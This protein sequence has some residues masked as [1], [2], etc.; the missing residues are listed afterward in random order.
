MRFPEEVLHKLADIIRGRPI[1]G[2]DQA[3]T[4]TFS[5]AWIGSYFSQFGGDG[6]YPPENSPDV[7]QYV[8]KFLVKVNGTPSMD[9]LL[10]A[11]P[12]FCANEEREQFDPNA[13][14]YEI[15]K[16]I[17]AH[18]VSL[19]KEDETFSGFSGCGFSVGITRQEQIETVS[20]IELNDQTIMEH[21]EKASSKIENE[22]YAGAISSSYTLIEGFL[23]ELLRRLDITFNPDEG[24]IRKL[25][26]FAADHLNLN[27]KGEHLESYLKAILQGIKSQVSGLYEL[28]NKAS[29]R[30]ARRYHPARHH[31]KLAVNASFTLCEFLLDSFVYQQQRSERKVS[32]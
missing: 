30:H 25:Y 16:V 8:F 4:P 15:N 29:D 5:V 14:A 19:V 11:L 9:G 20:L 32:A 18:G 1:S 28:A 26:V 17:S 10:A 12:S 24:D 21:V 31:A 6:L 3:I 23:K 13:I 2:Y 27:P 7:E 22:D